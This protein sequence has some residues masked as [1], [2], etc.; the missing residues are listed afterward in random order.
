MAEPMTPH[1]FSVHCGHSPR[2]IFARRRFLEAYLRHHGFSQVHSQV[3][4]DNS[5]VYSMTAN[6]RNYCL[7]VSDAW[8]VS[9]THSRVEERLQHLQVLSM[10]REHGSAYVDVSPTGQE[11][12]RRL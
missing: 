1:I 10:L 11:M 5:V 3:E 7:R 8:L 9:S 2:L 12:L 4:R 6:G